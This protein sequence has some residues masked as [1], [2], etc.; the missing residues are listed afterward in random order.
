MHIFYGLK[1]R[2]IPWSI[3]ELFFWLSF[4]FFMVNQ[5]SQFLFVPT[6]IFDDWLQLLFFFPLNLN[7]QSYA[8]NDKAT[9]HPMKQG[10]NAFCLSRYVNYKFIPACICISTIQI[11]LWVHFLVVPSHGLRDDDLPVLSEAHS[12]HQLHFSKCLQEFYIL[13]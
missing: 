13:K 4:R 2:K 3:N 5:Q 9:S 10:F 6:K 7:S 8:T 12:M 1:Y 11:T